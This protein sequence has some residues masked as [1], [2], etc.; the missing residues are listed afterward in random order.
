VLYGVLAA[1]ALSFLD[2]LHRVVRGHD[3]VL[4]FVPGIAGMHDIDDRPS[5]CQGWSCIA[6]THRCAL[7]TPT[8]SVGAR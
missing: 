1:V 8:I 5:L 2:L 7:P 6:A 4:G 3:S